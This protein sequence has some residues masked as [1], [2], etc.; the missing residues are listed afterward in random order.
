MIAAMDVVG[1]PSSVHAEGR[2]AKMIV[3]RARGQVAD[4][5]GCD[6]S[7]VV[8]TSGATEAV[9]LVC[10]RASAVHCGNWEHDCV[11]AW[12]ERKGGFESPLSKG[13]DL[14]FR[15]SSICAV[16]GANSEVGFIGLPSV[17]DGKEVVGGAYFTGKARILNDGTQ[18]IGKLGYGFTYGDVV[19]YLALSGH[20]IGAPKGVGALVVRTGIDIEHGYGGQEMGRRFGT[21][22]VI[23]IAGFGAAAVAAQRDLDAGVWERVA[24]MRDGMEAMILDAAPEAIVFGK[25]VPRLPNTSNFAIPGWRGETQ[26]MQMDLAGFAVSAGSACSSGKVKESRV[27]RA[28]GFDSETAS[29]AIRVSMGPT[30]TQAEVTSFAETWID[31]YRRFKRRAA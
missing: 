25:G 29:S 31:H 4:L 2:A 10:E 17:I 13:D 27:L 14:E 12:R 5:V 21:E 8:F 20:K 1:N 23:G 15:A 6:A 19:H 7:E 22:N 28:M 16:Q 30:T 18:L 9:S 11:L 26:V 3:E 24:E